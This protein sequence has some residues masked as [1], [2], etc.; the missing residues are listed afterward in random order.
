[1]NST[2]IVSKCHALV[3]GA[4]APLER[5]SSHCNQVCRVILLPAGAV[6]WQHDAVLGTKKNKKK[7]HNGNSAQVVS[8]SNN[9]PAVWSRTTLSIC[10]QI[11]QD[12]A[13]MPVVALCH[14]LKHWLLCMDDWMIFHVLLSGLTGGLNLGV[15][16][17]TVYFPYYFSIF[18]LLDHASFLQVGLALTI[19]HI[20]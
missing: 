8:G 5:L 15:N 9:N 13:L 10:N 1:M 7:K 17:K 14:R 19:N 18:W 12:V 20:I 6:S 4:M 16:L 3:A 2:K 11:T